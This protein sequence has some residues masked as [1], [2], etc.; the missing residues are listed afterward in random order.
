MPGSFSPSLLSLFLFLP[1]ITC[2]ALVFSF[3]LWDILNLRCRFGLTPIFGAGIIFF[4]YFFLS[5][6]YLC[7]YKSI[8]Y[9]RYMGAT[10]LR[11][12]LSLVE[13]IYTSHELAL[14][15][16]SRA[17]CVNLRLWMKPWKVVTPDLTSHPI[18][19]SHH[20][21]HHPSPSQHSPIIII[22]HHQ[23]L[24]IPPAS[25]DSDSPIVA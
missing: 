10:R 14:H 8:E 3:G 16:L 5:P 4:S 20:Q 22:I 1:K 25:P 11:S 6:L 9:I 13:S 23:N 7:L 19:S 17:L 24:L 21:H 15:I 2:R 18:P 12:L